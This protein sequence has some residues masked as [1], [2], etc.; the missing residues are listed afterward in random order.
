MNY[1]QRPLTSGDSSSLG[2]QHQGA[3]SFYSCLERYD[4][5]VLLPNS[6]DWETVQN[7]RPCDSSLR[8]HLIWLAFVLTV[9]QKVDRCFITQLMR[10]GDCPKYEPG[11]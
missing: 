6:H 3:D 10:L 5:D 9:T 11:R 1:C 8:T 2:P 7:M 4:I